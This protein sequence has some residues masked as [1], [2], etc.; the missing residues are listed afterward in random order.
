MN[1]GTP[2]ESKNVPYRFFIRNSD[3]LEMNQQ[4]I[5]RGCSACAELSR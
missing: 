4:N 1:Q 2:R 5:L 3:L